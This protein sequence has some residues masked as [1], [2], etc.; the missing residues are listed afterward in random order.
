SR[1][2]RYA[3]RCWR[4]RRSSGPAT[5]SARRPGPAR[6]GVGPP[7]RA[8][9]GSPRSPAQGVT[10]G[11]MFSRRGAARSP[12]APRRPSRRGASRGP[13]RAP[14]RRP[15]V[16]PRAH[17]DDLVDRRRRLRTRDDLLARGLAVLDQ[18]VVDDGPAAGL[19]LGDD[20]GLPEVEVRGGA[21]GGGERHRTG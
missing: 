20:P 10:F 16:L 1:R 21:L 7:A 9:P 4:R 13:A 14:P 11:R 5:W 18:D 3:A 12:T 8:G 19:A 15:L 17:L 6:A 2:A